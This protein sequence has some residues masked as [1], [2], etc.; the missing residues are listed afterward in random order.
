M[1]KT[2]HLLLTAWIATVAISC[3][4]VCQGIGSE[5]LC[6]VLEDS[7][8]NNLI[9]QNYPNLSLEMSGPESSHFV[10][11]MI[12][13]SISDSAKA[14]YFNIEK[15]ISG[16]EYLLVHDSLTVDTLVV[17]WKTTE[18]SKDKNAY[19]SIESVRYN[20]STYSKGGVLTFVR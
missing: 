5:E 8:G 6:I 20:D 4:K 12:V 15:L 16:Y 3:K 9:H 19:R 7:D 17:N 14:W 13:S 2:T 10:N 1:K 18:C 11:S